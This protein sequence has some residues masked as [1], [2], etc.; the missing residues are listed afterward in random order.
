LPTQ[1]VIQEGESTISL[2]DELGFFPETIWNDGGNSA[3]REKRERMNVLLPGDTL[4][5]PDNGLKSVKKPVDQKYK[6]RRKGIP[7]IFRLQVFDVE[8]PR[9]NQKYTLTV[10]GK[11]ISGVTDKD[12]I[13]QEYVPAQSKEAELVIGPDEFRV[14]I[15]FGLLDPINEVF[16]VQKRLNNLGYDCGEPD[17]T[18][19]DL[20]QAALEKFQQRFDLKVTRTND[21]ATVQKLRQIHD[22]SARFPEEPA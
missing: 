1:R 19:N 14:T 5:I 8:D 2:A 18:L 20:T 15:R 22:V 17:G 7:A 12:G 9:A 11:E 10:D 16:G 3:L 13:L 4:T 6:F 21:D